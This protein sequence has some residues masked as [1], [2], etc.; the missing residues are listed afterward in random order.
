REFA[1]L[2]E[3]YGS[4]N[5]TAS[6]RISP[7]QLSTG[8]PTDT[9]SSSSSS[10]SESPQLLSPKE[11][12]TAY[13]HTPHYTTTPAY[14]MHTP[15]HAFSD[16]VIQLICVAKGTGLG[17]VVKGG[18]NRAEGPM[19]FIQEIVP[20]GDC[21]KVGDQLVSINKESLIGVTYE[22]VRSILTRTKL[23]PDPTVEI[24]FIR[25]RSSSSSSSGSHSPVC[26]QGCGG[27][28]GSQTK[29]PGM[30]SAAPQPVMVTKITSSR[31]PT[32][33][34]LPPVNVTQVRVSPG[35]TEQTGVSSA[36]QSD[37]SVDT[38]PNSGSG[39][40]PQRKCSLSSSCRF[41]LERLE[42]VSLESGL[43]VKENFVSSLK[44]TAPSQWVHLVQ[45]VHLQKQLCSNVFRSKQ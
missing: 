3:K 2:M 32:C 36:Q 42:Q 11:G 24:A 10:R 14:T 34:T 17:L 31:N 15:V 22:E 20:G 9:A 30:S 40:A 35:R 28:A 41:K 19:V 43:N 5:V 44:K 13:S 27:G 21:Q 8:K 33:E 45:G 37:S 12:I 39:Q 6:G 23:R 26:L 38:N 1:E 7:T 4:N 25:P 16:S 18:T 29:A